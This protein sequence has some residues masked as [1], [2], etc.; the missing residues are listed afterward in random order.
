MLVFT[1]Y[2]TGVCVEGELIK[3]DVETTSKFRL[4]KITNKMKA[5]LPIKNCGSKLQGV[6]IKLK[7]RPKPIKVDGVTLV[8][9]RVSIRGVK[10]TVYMLTIQ[11]LSDL[12]LTA[13]D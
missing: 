1:P 9:F 8:P 2:D 4:L 6:I 13:F 7:I 10:N 11:P 3:E 5:P 12:P